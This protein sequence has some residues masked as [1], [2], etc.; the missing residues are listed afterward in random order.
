MTNRILS[1]LTLLCLTSNL[2]GCETELT[3]EQLEQLNQVEINDE[4]HADVDANDELRGEDANG[5]EGRE[6]V[7]VDD[8]DGREPVFFD[9]DDGRLPADAHAEPV[10]QFT[11]MVPQPNAG[12]LSCTQGN[13]CRSGCRCTNAG[14][15]DN[16]GIGP[17]PPA[18]FCDVPPERTCSSAGDC[19]DGCSCYSGSCR[20]TPGVS[21]MP[22]DPSCHLPPGDDYEE[23]DG[24]QNWSAYTGVPQVHNFDR[25]HDKDW[26]AVYIATAATVVFETTNLS[27]GT[28]TKL[29]VFDFSDHTIGALLG[30]ND[31]RGGAWFDPNS[32]GSRVVLDVP[33]DS[34]YLM[35]IVN[36]GGPDPFL[37]DHQWPTYTLKLSAL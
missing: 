34:F 25:T 3:L 4:D 7:Y 9:D 23:D 11:A 24:W 17:F 18:G 16:L 2:G 20:Q 14:V 13:D 12:T 8:A 19:R 36:K 33:A 6:P 22:P 30:Q 10:E 15:C 29:K 32:K 37:N 31:D 1:V 28:D 26:V 5:E 27:W 21:P 35:K